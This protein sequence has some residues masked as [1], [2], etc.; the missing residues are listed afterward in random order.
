[1]DTAD[2]VERTGGDEETL[3]E[4][5]EYVARIRRLFP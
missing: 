4:G 2:F 5:A 1:M 3:R